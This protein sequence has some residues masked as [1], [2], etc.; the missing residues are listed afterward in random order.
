MQ[1][2]RT[3]TSYSLK[4][5]HWPVEWHKYQTSNLIRPLWSTSDI[6]N[7]HHPLSF[8]QRMTK[9]AN[10]WWA[11]HSWWNRSLNR[12]P[13]RHLCTFQGNERFVGGYRC[14]N[15]CGRC[16]NDA[17]YRFGTTGRRQS[18]VHR[19]VLSSLQLR[20]RVFQCTKEEVCIRHKNRKQF[21]IPLVLK[22]RQ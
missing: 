19:L 9:I 22:L 18:L 17:E 16:S 15:I 10:G 12:M 11:M 14:P 2:Q 6:T 8:R 7:Q 1:C 21:R 20:S 13:C 3:R 5:C 4:Y